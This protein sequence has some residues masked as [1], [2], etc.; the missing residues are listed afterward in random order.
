MLSMNGRPTF[1]EMLKFLEHH[2]KYLQR[3]STDKPDTNQGID[4]KKLS[5]KSSSSKFSERRTSYATTKKLCPL[6]QESHAIYHC[7]KLLALPVE[8]R[9][10]EIRKLRFCFNC[11]SPGHQNRQCKSGPCTKCYRKHNSLLHLDYQK[12]VEKQGNEEIQALNV[13]E[14]SASNQ[15]GKTALVTNVI[16]SPENE[17]VMLGTAIVWVEDNLGKRH[18]CRVLLDSCSQVHLMTQRLCKLLKLPVANSNTIVSGVFKTTQD[19]TLL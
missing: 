2:C 3:V 5:T 4:Q 7:E 15:S 13:Q 9:V 1:R 10:N 12:T 19:T 11:L 16:L 17:D 14:E 8:S 6:C 18:E